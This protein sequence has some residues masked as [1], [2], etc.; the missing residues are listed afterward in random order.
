MW[1]ALKKKHVKRALKHAPTWLQNSETRGRLNPF[2][3]AAGVSIAGSRNTSRHSPT[4][5]S[6]PSPGCEA[7]QNRKCDW[8]QRKIRNSPTTSC[9]HA[10][11]VRSSGGVQIW[12]EGVQRRPRYSVSCAYACFQQWKAEST[13]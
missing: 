3:F 4:T 9:R 8:K 10:L 12:T 6:P 13:S 5:A 2:R 11:G 1:T 7:V